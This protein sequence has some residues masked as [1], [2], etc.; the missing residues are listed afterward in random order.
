[1]TRHAVAQHFPRSRR[2]HRTRLLL[3]LLA[4]PVPGRR[5]RGARGRPGPVHG[6]EL[7]DAQA[8]Q[9]ALERKIESQRALDR[10]AS[11]APRT[12]LDGPDRADEDQLDG[13][14]D[15][16]S[17]TRKRVAALE[18]DIGEV[19]AAYEGLVNQLADLDLQLAA[20]RAAGDAKKREQLRQRKAELADRIRQ[21]YEAERTSMLETFLSGASFTDMLAEM[22][23]Q[24]DA[25]E[26]DRALAQQIAQDRETLLALHQTVEATRGRDRTSSARRRRSRSRSWTSGWTS[27]R[28]AQAQPQGAREGGQGGA[29]R[30]RRRS[31]RSWPPTRAKLR[32]AIAAAA[33]ARSASSSTRSTA[34][35]PSSSTTATSRPSTTG[36]SAGRWAGRSP[37]TSAAPGSRG[38]RRQRLRP[39]PQR[40][41]HR[42]AV[43][44][45]GP[46]VGRRPGRV[47]RLELR[48][49]RRPGLDRDHRPLLEPHH[50]VRPHAAALPGAAPARPS[51]RARSSATR[52]TPATRPA[53]TSTGWSSSTATS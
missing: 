25:A 46:R 4:G 28:K 19:Q 11:T 16:L 43:R 3:A 1:M 17:A 9:Q 42:G 38:S 40:H 45:A 47:L 51:G 20:H 30:A 14:T 39:L 12:A 49:R 48:R 26:Q 21:A 24:L 23:T 53:R 36:R 15:D 41:R 31:T 6:D 2:G 22:S 34:S 52:A 33:A 35:S 7:A 18:D 27:S 37:G 5:D 13:I 8:Q 29:R 32:R 10:A 44:H 50:L